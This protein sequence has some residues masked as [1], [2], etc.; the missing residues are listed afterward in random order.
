LLRAH[1]W[2]V[3][4]QARSLFPDIIAFKKGRAIALECKVAKWLS[5]S[6]MEALLELERKYGFAPLR[7]FPC[8]GKL[9]IEELVGVRAS[10]RGTWHPMELKE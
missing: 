3:I 1:G 7:G 6:E 5:R 4:H 9:M 8:Q 10:G 2:Y